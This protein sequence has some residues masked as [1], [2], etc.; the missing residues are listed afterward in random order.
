MKRLIVLLL[1]IASLTGA[2]QTT[3]RI[4][5]ALTTSNNIRSYIAASNLV[6]NAAQSNVLLNITTSTPPVR[7]LFFGITTN[8]AVVQ[9]NETNYWWFTNGILTLITNSAT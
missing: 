2:A 9:P 1:C 3:N 8:V 5:S 6:N 4:W 7:T